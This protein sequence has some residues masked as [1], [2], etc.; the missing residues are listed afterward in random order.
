MVMAF[1][2][3]SLRG[4]VI[5]IACLAAV[6]ESGLLCARRSSVVSFFSR[7]DGVGNCDMRHD[8]VRKSR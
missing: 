1:P 4:F 8:G 2:S 3:S 7:E 6:V 5:A